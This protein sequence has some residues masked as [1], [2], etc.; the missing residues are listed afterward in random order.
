MWRPCDWAR[1]DA[2]PRA[3]GESFFKS[4]GIGYHGCMIRHIVL[5][6]FKDAISPEERRAFIARL[7]KLPQQIAE[8]KE[9]EVGED[10]TRAARSYDLALVATYEDEEALQRYAE[11]PDHLPVVELSR[12]LC[13]HI[14]AV[15][16]VAIRPKATPSFPNRMKQEP[17]GGDERT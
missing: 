14:V 4:P 11:H 6:K 5:F 16:Y 2:I 10:I 15:D 8:I 17:G 7:K 3:L 1:A 9:F 12:Q 13:Q